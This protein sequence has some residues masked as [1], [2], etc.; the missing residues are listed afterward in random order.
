MINYSQVLANQERYADFVRQADND[1]LVKT[2][3]AGA[4]RRPRIWR[5][6]LYWSGRRLLAWGNALV[7]IGAQCGPSSVEDRVEPAGV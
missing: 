2:A 1:R 3:L 6:A 5:R 7:R 4:E